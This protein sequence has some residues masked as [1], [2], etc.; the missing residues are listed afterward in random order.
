[1]AQL[2]A[3]KRARP[4]RSLD[5]LAA[6]TFESDQELEEFLAFIYSERHRDLAWP[7]GPRCGCSGHWRGV[8]AAEA[9]ADPAV[10]HAA[11]WPRGADQV[12]HH[13]RARQVGR[14]PRLGRATPWRAGYLA[15]RVAVLPGDE[16]V[17]ATWGTLSAAPRTAEGPARST[18]CGSQRVV[19][20]TM[21][22]SPHWTSS[23]TRTSG[24]ITACASWAWP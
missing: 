16:A 12:C 4:V 23:T 21:S 22:R 14:D 15:G 1:V 10:G 24:S 13:R 3:A 11:D 7:R 8:A 6:D 9:H 5:E 18:T 20:P 19:S 2:L 17:A